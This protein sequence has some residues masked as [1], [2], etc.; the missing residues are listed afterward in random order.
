MHFQQLCPQEPVARRP[1]REHPHHP[2][3]F[4]Q[5]L[6]QVLH[7]VRR[8]KPTSMV[9]REGQHRQAIFQPFPQH[10]RHR[11]VSPFPLRRHLLTPTQALRAFL[12][13]KHHDQVPHQFPQHLVRHLPAQLPLEVHPAP[14][15]R[16]PLKVTLHR[17]HDPRVRVARH[18]L[19]PLQPPVLQV[20]EQLPP[21]RFAL[22][23]SHTPI[24]HFPTSFGCKPY[25]YQHRLAH[26]TALHTHLLVPRVNVQ[27]HVVRLVQ[28]PVAERQQLLVQFTG[29]TAHRHR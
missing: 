6:H 18:Q 25:G 8:P 23:V 5:P 22:A 15:P 4:L 19:Q 26:H 20:P 29:H 27:V 11:R 13:G 21:R 12:R 1:A 24:Q 16:H 17:R 14:L 2:R 3:P 10:L 9:L 28:T 7:H